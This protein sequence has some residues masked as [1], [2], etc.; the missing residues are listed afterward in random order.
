[1]KK[2]ERTTNLVGEAETLETQNI[3]LKAQMRSLEIERRSLTEMLQLHA[4]SCAHSEGIQIPNVNAA[5]TKCLIELGLGNGQQSTSSGS[6]TLI[7][8]KTEPATKAS[9]HST[10]SG[11]QRQQKIPSVNTLKFGTRRGG[12]GQQGNK[13]H[14]SATVTGIATVASIV[15]SSAA[16]TVPTTRNCLIGVM[17]TASP[18]QECKPLPSIDMGFCESGNES[19]TP[20]S[21]YCKSLM[22]T[23]SDCYAI[24]SPDSG[25]IKSP[26]DMGNYSTL[27]Q[28]MKSDY[29][30][31]C[32]TGMLND[33]SVTGA[34]V[35]N[36]DNSMEFILKSEL[37]DANESPYTTVQSADRFLFDGCAEAF[38]PDMDGTAPNPNHISLIEATAAHMHDGL[39]EH[40]MLHG[41]NNNNNNSTHINNNHHHHH[42]H[43][44]H[45]QQHHHHQHGGNG[46]N[47][48]NLDTSAMMHDFGVINNLPVI[49]SVL[50]PPSAQPPHST[51][52]IEF[53]T[54]CQPYIDASLLKGDFLSQNCDFLDSQFTTDLDSGVTTYTNSSGCL[55]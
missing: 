40:L 15:S 34:A 49:S 8:V 1:M 9:R 6:D 39:K 35:G 4:N 30:P 18:I 53:N 3:D 7:S 2:R 31:N 27:P 32:D 55:A 19:L 33:T 52:I 13:L 24:S 36:Q 43:P 41:L 11:Q 14:Q 51:S 25:F 23:S 12:G 45:H 44:H 28:M 20:T 37:V 54:A 26:V 38:D 48:G 5:I 46:G 16:A 50:T 22:S 17:S 21:S 47:G 29:I 10:K 42:Q